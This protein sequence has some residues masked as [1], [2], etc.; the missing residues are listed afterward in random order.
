MTNSETNKKKIE[1][2]EKL[3]DCDI[4]SFS[5]H[6]RKD[7]YLEFAMSLGF[8]LDAF[9]N[10]SLEELDFKKI[11]FRGEYLDDFFR[12]PQSQRTLGPINH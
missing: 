1:K 12:L 11:T 7:D 9:F 10:T 8:D 5:N 2:L 3:L 6:D 4:A